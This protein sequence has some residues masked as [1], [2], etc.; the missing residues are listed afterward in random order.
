MT[1]SEKIRFIFRKYSD[2][3]FDRAD[4]FWKYIIEFIIQTDAPFITKDQFYAFYRQFW[5]LEREV[6]NII[7]E[8]EFVLPPENQA[9]IQELKSGFQKTYSTKK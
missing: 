9:K 6:R 2:S 1:N 5:G 7:K 8:K 3:K 4:F